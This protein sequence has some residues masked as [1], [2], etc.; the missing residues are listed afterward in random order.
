MINSFED[1]LWALF[2]TI[3]ASRH[4]NSVGNASELSVKPG[5]KGNHELRKLDCFVI[6]D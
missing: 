1:Q 5:T 2:S 3:K 4:Q 6:Y